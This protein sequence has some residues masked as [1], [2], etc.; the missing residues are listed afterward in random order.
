MHDLAQTIGTIGDARQDRRD[1]DAGFDA[2]VHE[3]AERTQPLMRRRRARL[4]APPDLTIESG[5]REVDLHAGALRQLLQRVHVADDHR[6][7]R[8]DA[9]GRARA[10]EHLEARAR[11]S[12]VSLRGLIDVRRGADRDDVSLP[13]LPRELDTQHVCDVHLDPAFQFS[14]E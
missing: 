9:R 8:D 11:Q 6:P 5:H 4:R 12:I 1:P 13:R 2:R 14:Y 10:R 7:A 3:H